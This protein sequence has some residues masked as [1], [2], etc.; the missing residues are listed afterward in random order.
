VKKKGKKYNIKKTKFQFLIYNLLE[1]VQQS[2]FFA[3]QKF[4]FAHHFI[5]L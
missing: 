3:I 2:V 1:T 5:T 4:Y